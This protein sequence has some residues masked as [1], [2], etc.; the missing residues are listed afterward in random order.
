MGRGAISAEQRSSKIR[1]THNKYA[2]K[3]IE[4]KKGPL[5]G[6]CEHRAAKKIDKKKLKNPPRGIQAKAFY[7]ENLANKRTLLAEIR[8]NNCL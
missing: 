1:Q 6:R 7:C 8:T 4:K 3:K 5:K 2:K